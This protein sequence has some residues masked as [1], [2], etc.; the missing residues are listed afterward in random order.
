MGLGLLLQTLKLPKGSQILCSATKPSPS[1][2][3]IPQARSVFIATLLV[4]LLHTGHYV[5][6]GLTQVC[7]CLQGANGIVLGYDVSDRRS[8]DNVGYWMNN[9]RQ[10]SSPTQMPA[11]LL[12]G[13]KIDLPN[14]VVTLEE[15]EAAASQ[16][17]CRFIGTLSC[18][19]RNGSLN[20]CVLL[21]GVVETSATTSEKRTARSKPL[22]AMRS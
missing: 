19:C 14:P 8:F 22:R 11:M 10:Y 21:V 5:T 7:G 13:N 2:S 18:G 4:S 16:Y 20:S 15:G 9:I 17:R 12:V 3:G 6:V 1:R